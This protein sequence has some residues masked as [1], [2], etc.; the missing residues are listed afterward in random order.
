MVVNGIIAISCADTKGAHEIGG[1]MGPGCNYFC[2]A[3]FIHRRDI[4]KHS[5]TGRL[6]MRNAENYRLG[7]EA[8]E[9]HEAPTGSS[10]DRN[11]GLKF[12]SVVNE[13]QYFHVA[14]SPI[15]DT[16]H[17][18]LERV[19]PFLLMS[20]IRSWNSKKNTNIRLRQMN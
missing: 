3:C 19:G 6:V 10:G 18:I 12:S 15:F 8:A 13:S 7:T 5:S 20:C 17:D 2:R 11:T 9:A 14:E 16:M 4:L 1:C